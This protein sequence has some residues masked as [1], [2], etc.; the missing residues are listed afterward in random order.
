M[1]L[2]REHII[3]IAVFV[4]LLACVGGGYQFY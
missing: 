3:G 1:N 2:R 4:L